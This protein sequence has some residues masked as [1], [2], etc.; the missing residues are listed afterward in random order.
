M[1]DKRDNWFEILL[2]DQELKT[3]AKAVRVKLHTFP[4]G[5]WDI[6]EEDWEKLEVFI[7]DSAVEKAT[8]HKP[9][10]PAKTDK[11]GE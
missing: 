6:T 7:R 2:S 8:R 11:K 4:T 10:E 3:L 9:V 1:T 5:G